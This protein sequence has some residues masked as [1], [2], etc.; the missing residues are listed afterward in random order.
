MTNMTL[1]QLIQ[2]AYN[3]RQSQVAGPDW[4]KNAHFDLAAKYPENTKSADRPV[5][6]RTLLE[7]K[8]KLAVHHENRMLTGYALLTAKGG[9]KLKPVEGSDDHIARHG[10]SEQTLTAK[11]TSMAA[12][13]VELMRILDAPVVD[14]TGI[15]GAYDFELHI[16]IDQSGANGKDPDPRAPFFYGLQDALPT[17]GLRLQP[18]KVPLDV[19]VV[20]H[21]ERTPVDN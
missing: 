17:I 16:T 12:F 3:V 10:G 20:D 4:L 19:I 9:F 15:P 7:D 11:Q 2:R 14:E 1:E 5:M 6:L 21:A 18:R 8:F 13:V